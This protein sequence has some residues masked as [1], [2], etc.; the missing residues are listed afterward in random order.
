MSYLRF[1]GVFLTDFEIDD[2][3]WPD[4]PKLCKT[5][6]KNN[7]WYEVFK[8]PSLSRSPRSGGL[9]AIRAGENSSFSGTVFQLHFR[10]EKPLSGDLK[11][12]APAPARTP[13]ERQPGGDYG[14]TSGRSRDPYLHHPP[15]TPGPPSGPCRGLR[16]GP[17]AGPGDRQWISR[18]Y[19]HEGLSTREII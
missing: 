18:C 15:R 19:A 11:T 16:T 1:C 4:W 3:T 5:L 10:D 12:F 17:A 9:R 14:I 13:T 6:N 2:F 7:T 8:V